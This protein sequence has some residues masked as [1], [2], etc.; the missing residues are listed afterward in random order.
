MG[1]LHG[2]PVSA[3]ED[4][5]VNEVGGI[6][7]TVEDMVGLVVGGSSQTGQLSVQSPGQFVA[8]VVL[9]RQPAVDEVEGDFAQRVAAHHPGAA[10]SQQQQREQLQRAAVLSGQGEG[11]VV[12]V[13]LPVGVTVEP[14][15]PDEKHTDSCLRS[16]FY[17]L[18]SSEQECPRVCGSLQFLL[19][20][21]PQHLDWG[22][23]RRGEARRTGG[24]KAKRRQTWGPCEFPLGGVSSD[25]RG[26]N[27]FYLPVFTVFG[28]YWW[29]VLGDSACRDQWGQQLFFFLFLG[30]FIVLWIDVHFL[31][32]SCLLTCRLIYW[33]LGRTWICASRLTYRVVLWLLEYK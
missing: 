15:N 10:H 4:I 20:P 33:V 24:K 18:G 32:A 11:V 8:T 22:A 26:L 23:R 28:E 6:V 9:H 19:V 14:G 5:P 7:D 12:L 1:T 16:H 17:C 21:L 27:W 30:T 13:V 2:S 31:F 3:K 25:M 29:G